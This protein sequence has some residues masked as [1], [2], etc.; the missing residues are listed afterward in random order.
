MSMIDRN[1]YECRS[2]GTF[3][4]LGEQIHDHDI[5]VPATLF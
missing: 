5:E 4:V 3:Q 1:C 2:W